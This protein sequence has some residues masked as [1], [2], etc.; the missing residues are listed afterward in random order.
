MSEQELEY[1]YPFLTDGNRV[2]GSLSRFRQG[3]ITLKPG[4]ITLDGKAVLPNILQIPIALGGMLLM[5][6]GL[7]LSAI[8]LEYVIRVQHSEVHLWE[9]IEEVVY[10]KQKN[11][12]CLI[13]RDIDRPKRK[14]GL[15]LKL[16]PELVDNFLAAIDYFL[17]EKRRNGKVH[18]FSCAVVAVIF[19][20]IF[21]FAIFI[22]ISVLPKGS[23]NSFEGTGA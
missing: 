18:S 20:F 11:R 1:N 17:P 7:M 13:F 21:L 5:G 12:I 22:L 9:N 14:T 16:R 6:V 15:T 10:D 19:L 2:R 4:G 23:S 3:T 8:L